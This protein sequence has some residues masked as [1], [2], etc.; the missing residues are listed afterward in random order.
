MTNY[1]PFDLDPASRPIA[2]PSAD[3]FR[4]PGGKPDTVLENRAE[5]SQPAASRPLFEAARQSAGKPGRT[6]KPVGGKTT[7][8]GEGTQSSARDNDSLEAKP[9]DAIHA[10]DSGVSG[11]PDLDADVEEPA[12]SESP[13]LKLPAFAQMRIVED[14]LRGA[15][16]ATVGLALLQENLRWPGKLRFEPATGPEGPTLEPE[17]SASV[18]LM[19]GEQNFGNLVLDGGSASARMLEQLRQSG[20]WL[21]AMLALA[22]QHQNLRRLADTDELSGAYNRRYFSEVVPRLLDKA[23]KER[24]CVTILLFDIDDFKQ[25][26][27]QFGHAAGD[28][29]IREVIGLL[30]HCT[31]SQDMVARIGGDEFAVVFWDQ[32]ALRQPDSQHPRS[33]LNIAQRFRKAVAEH[34]WNTDGGPIA[35]RLSISGGLATFPWDASNLEQ[36]MAVADG[37]LMRAKSMGKNAIVLAGPGDSSP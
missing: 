16:V 21:S 2:V 32:G 8:S 22:Q 36:I 24:F 1:N 15:N 6:G 3:I 19:A 30:R 33:V 27:D 4:R 25:Y 14:I 13:T 17:A 31:R 11:E 37:E 7:A 35:G 26:N 20:L 18:R 29:I 28:A 12:I 5:A 23:R 34:P 10:A 9:S